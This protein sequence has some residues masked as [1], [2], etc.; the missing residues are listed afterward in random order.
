MTAATVLTDEHY[1]ILRAAERSALVCVGGRWQIRSAVFP[2]YDPV[3][4][5]AS[6]RKL[7]ARGLIDYPRFDPSSPITAWLRVELDTLVLTDKGREVL[8]A[9]E[10]TT[11]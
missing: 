6:R 10:G 11:P 9:A 2:Y 3:P 5:F 4:D 8:A 7:I 1:R